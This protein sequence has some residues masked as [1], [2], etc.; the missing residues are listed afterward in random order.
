MTTAADTETRVIGLAGWSGAGKTTLLVKLIP[1]LVAR[2]L[3]VSTLKHAHHGFD[4]DR[5]GK[6]SYAHR[7][8]GATEVLISS[9]RRYVL[10]HEVR[11][12]E[13][14]PPLAALLRRMAAVDLLVVEGFKS[15]AHP[16]IEV[17]RA[18]NGKPLLLGQSPNI[19]AIAT[20][21]G[22][23]DPGVPVV[24]LDDVGA[25]AELAV[26]LAEPLGQVL[27]DLEGLPRP[28][29]LSPRARMT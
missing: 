6:D 24:H 20:D 28:Q 12:G 25:I 8:A 3:R 19:R 27:A 26:S 23:G 17:H 7:S 1:A 13:E 15:Y 18:A 14:E 29:R 11:S 16:K 2:G 5:P 4:V 21:A 22:L 9:A 10:M